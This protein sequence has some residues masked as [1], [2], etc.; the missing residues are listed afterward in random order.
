METE[1]LDGLSSLVFVRFPAEWPTNESDQVIKS[2]FL[3]I[4]SQVCFLCGS[5]KMFISLSPYKSRTK[6]KIALNSCHDERCYISDLTRA[7]RTHRVI[8]NTLI[9]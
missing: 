2:H 4:A 3:Y 9:K 7:V 6:V 5:L 8:R 1:S